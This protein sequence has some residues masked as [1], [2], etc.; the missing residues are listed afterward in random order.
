MTE[1]P[2]KQ[3]E[4]PARPRRRGAD[5]ER[6]RGGRGRGRSS[7]APRGGTSRDAKL[8]IGDRLIDADSIETFTLDDLSSDD[9]AAAP[10]AGRGYAANDDGGDEVRRRRRRRGG[11]GRRG[12]GGSG[13]GQQ[14]AGFAGEEIETLRLDDLDEGAP[15]GV[16]EYMAGGRN[17]GGRGASSLASRRALGSGPSRIADEVARSHKDDD[18]RD[19]DGMSE[20]APDVQALLRSQLAST[21]RAASS[22]PALT[23]KDAPAAKGGRGGA[24]GGRAAAKPTGK[25]GAKKPAT[26]KPAAKVAMVKKPARPKAKGS[27]RA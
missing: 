5:E 10:S 15:G 16:P 22:A 2:G 11:R 9:L 27:K 13:S 19:D 8:R 23:G 17:G 24:R 26:K 25:A 7:A 6:P 21:G 1:V 12:R 14:G 20:V 4:T 3:S 18:F